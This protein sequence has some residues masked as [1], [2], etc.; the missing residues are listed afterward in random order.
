MDPSANE[1]EP[2]FEDNSGRIDDSL[3]KSQLSGNF[4]VLSSSF[5]TF[6]V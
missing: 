1:W 5:P 4:N 3:D 2:L 6:S